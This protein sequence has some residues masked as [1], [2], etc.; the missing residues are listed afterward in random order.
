MKNFRLSKDNKKMVYIIGIGGISLS[1]IAYFLRSWGYQVCGSD[2]HEN[3]QTEKLKK[4]GFNVEICSSSPDFVKQCDVV[5]YTSAIDR[6]NA[7]IML[8]KKMKKIILSRA[9]VLGEISKKYKTISVAG[10]HGKTTTTG[11]I[12]CLLSENN[13]QPNIHIGGILN[14]I[15]SN[16]YFGESDVFVTEACEYKDSFLLL[17]NYVSVVLNVRE[18][19]LDYFHNLKNIFLSFKKF[20]KNTNKEGCTVLNYDDPL[21]A[22][23]KPK[24][25]ILSFAI[26]NKATVVAKDI[27]KIGCG[28]YCF[29]VYYRNIKLGNVN[30]PCYGFHNIYNA[31]A[32]IC[33]GIFF[34]IDFKNIK[35]G[36]EKFGG[37]KRRNEILFENDDVVIFH[38]YA[39][40]PDEI[41]ATLNS[42][43]D[44]GF[45]KIVT[46]FQPHTF[47]RT[48]DLHSDFVTCFEKSDK[49]F[50]LPIYPAREKPI[51]GVTSHLL[52]EDI[53]KLGTDCVALKSFEECEDV[54]EKK[55]LQSD[56]TLNKT[57]LNKFIN[58]Y[59]KK[60]K[61]FSKNKK[62]QLKSKNKNFNKT[63]KNKQEKILIAFLGA[64]DIN[65]LAEKIANKLNSKLI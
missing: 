11:M 17:K 9:E 65:L 24:S 49:V 21:T 52:A 12:S 54:L 51:E 23:L 18:D 61:I 27:R 63:I 20:V 36:L 35:S 53:K 56:K 39:H 55:Y 26:K 8:A 46:V 42:Y 62:F 1:A 38:D 33:V 64:G 10:T 25:N 13:F 28:K 29:D 41:K 6:Q 15:N 57:Q 14:N 19:H 5:I 7:D 44:L 40:H 50:L 2:I 45:D 22:K 60:T 32:S 16:Y 48:K 31:L 4:D 30:L 37:V 3:E 43:K 47:S 34:E 59:N 58:K